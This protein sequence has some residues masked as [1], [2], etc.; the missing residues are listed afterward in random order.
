MNIR[1]F[2]IALPVFGAIVLQFNLAVAATSVWLKVP[3]GE[4]RLISAASPDSLDL[5]AALEIKLEEGWKTYWRAPGDSGI[6][7]Q[8]SFFGS[9]NVASVAFDFPTPSFYTDF[10]TQSVGYK[11]RVVFP[12]SVRMLEQNQPTVLNLNAIIGICS[13]ICVP[14][15]AKLTLN[16]PGT[17]SPT[18]EVSRIINDAKNSVPTGPGPDFRV[19]SAKWSP[20]NPGQLKILAVVPEG[21]SSVQVHVEGPSDWYL[22]PAKPDDNQDSSSRRRFVLDISDIPEDAK[23]ASTELRFTLVA[24][25]RGVEQLLIPGE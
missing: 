18:F 2:L 17:I 5:D 3:G 23:P 20:D 25:G 10:G 1:S 21:S 7:P 12:I 4:M 15:Q 22:L 19:T 11:N 9:S 16:E 14:V 13:E 6:P 8:F 24:D